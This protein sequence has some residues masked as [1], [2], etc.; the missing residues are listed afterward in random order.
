M[1]DA[2]DAGS[3][4]PPEECDI[5]DAIDVDISMSD[6]EGSDASDRHARLGLEDTLDIITDPLSSHPPVVFDSDE[7]D[8]DEDDEDDFSEDDSDSNQERMRHTEAETPLAPRSP[9]GAET[10]Q[11]ATGAEQTA[12]TGRSITLLIFLVLIGSDI[13][14]FVRPS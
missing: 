11:M 4:T 3:I 8:S 14:Q 12:Q 6:S 10:E 1:V 2:S 7:G 5:I 9:L 13:C